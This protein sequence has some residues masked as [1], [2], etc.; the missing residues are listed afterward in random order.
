MPLISVPYHLDEL[1]AD[2]ELP[3]A[4]E[5]TVDLPPGDVWSRFA[6]LYDAVAV[7]V[8]A[9]ARANPVTTVVSGDCTVMI[10]M[11]AGLQRA[12]IDPSIVWV[13]AHGDLQSLE[14]T[15]SGYLGGM[16]LRFL[17]G[18]RPD[19]VT[20]RLGIR[21]P[22]TDNVVLVDARDLDEAEADYLASTGLRRLRIDSLSAEALPPGPLLVNFD[23]DV[24]DPAV[25]PGVRYPAADGPGVET[26]L[27][28]ADTIFATGRV[29]GV[30]VACT[31]DPGYDDP[32]DVRAQVIAELVAKAG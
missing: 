10:G 1:L 30:N 8:E 19:L 31:W 21:P 26:L 5:L 29:V 17:L 25:V 3:P 4:A 15:T 28:A 11:T 24:L 27:T 13:D 2:L 18:Y 32:D 20:D 12:G 22:S 9:S 6:A 23:L 14:T 16:A 7:E